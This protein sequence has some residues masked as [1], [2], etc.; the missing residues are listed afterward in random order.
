[1]KF[2]CL[3]SVNPPR[4]RIESTEVLRMQPGQSPWCEHSL[5]PAVP[6]STEQCQGAAWGQEHRVQYCLS[7]GSAES[8]G[9]CCFSPV[10]PQPQEGTDV[11][12]PPL[13]HAVDCWTPLYT[14][15]DVK[16]SQAGLCPGTTGSS[17]AGSLTQNQ[18]TTAGMIK[19]CQE[20]DRAE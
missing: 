4:N 19:A 6:I 17:S 13:E 2:Q 20:R 8:S 9:L 16:V 5:P 11:L 14:S 12:V 3:R 1:M 7:Q 18:T 10:S 15:T